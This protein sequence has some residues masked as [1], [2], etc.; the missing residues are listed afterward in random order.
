[1][2]AE[3]PSGV[4]VV[5][6]TDD[7]GLLRP[8][9]DFDRRLVQGAL[10]NAHDNPAAGTPWNFSLGIESQAAD[11]VINDGG[12][13]SGNDSI[14]PNPSAPG[15][16]PGPGPVPSGTTVTDLRMSMLRTRLFERPQAELHSNFRGLDRDSYFKYGDTARLANLTTAH[17]NVFVVRMTTS[18]FI[19]DPTT[20]AVGEEYLDSTGEPLRT[21]AKLIVD[22]TIPVGFLPGKPL[23]TLDT[24]IYSEVQQ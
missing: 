24:V 10:L 13:S 17:S 4:G 19:V 21:K 1:M 11:L 14:V 15:P 18:Y 22:R 16:A 9:P 7:M 12:Q 20:G 2:R 3:D 8:H 5:R 6:R 23:N